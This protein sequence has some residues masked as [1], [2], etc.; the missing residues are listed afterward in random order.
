[1][2]NKLPVKEHLRNAA[3]Y[4]SLKESSPGSEW[5]RRLLNQFSMRKQLDDALRSKVSILEL[6]VC[7][8]V[9][10]VSLFLV[11]TSY[12]GLLPL[13]Q[14]FKDIILKNVLNLPPI[15]LKEILIFVAA[16]NSLTFLIMKRKLSF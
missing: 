13:G 3:L 6:T 16:V 8:V 1:M 11:F 12:F 7:I 5:K 4:Q 2:T 9:P 10:I 15:S 14:W